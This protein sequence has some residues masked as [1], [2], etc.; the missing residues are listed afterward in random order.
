VQAK[1]PIEQLQ[2]VGAP[3][4]LVEWFRKLAP[5]TA[6]RT[7]WVDAPRPDWLPYLA[8]LRGMT[9]DT[10]LRAVCE[11]T[12]ETIGAPDG[13]ETARVVAILAAAAQGGRGALAATETELADLKLAI[14]RWG[15]QTQPRPRPP[16]M[17]WAELLFELARATNRGNPLVGIA[18]AMRLLAHAMPNRR[19]QTDLV[20]LLREKLTLAG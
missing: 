9:P 4:E 16:W 2:S 20:A 6:P 7:A 3:R 5:D 18:L 14:V 13:P 19:A 8:V 11:C 17:K 12:L 15:H 10:I 1:K